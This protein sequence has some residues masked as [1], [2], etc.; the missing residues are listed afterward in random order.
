MMR[1]RF[2]NDLEIL[3]FI[4]VSFTARLLILK[5]KGILG[6]ASC[7]LS[8]VIWPLDHWVNLVLK[9]GSFPNPNPETGF[10]TLEKG[11]L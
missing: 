3:P 7:L 8:G 2:Q 9:A 11:H 4:Y 5:R 6:S 10:P 1:S